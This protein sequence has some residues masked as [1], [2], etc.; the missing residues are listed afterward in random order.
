MFVIRNR[1]TAK[2]GMATKLANTLREAM[3]HA[4]F[5]SRILTD[6]VG[7][8]NT[9]IMEHEVDSLSDFESRMKE[10]SEGSMG[11]EFGEKMK[12]YTDL[13]VTGNREIFKVM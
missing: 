3:V 2:P 4:P 12:G 8:F 13:Y 6:A 7:E 1:F 10:Y 9:V 5:K 11:K